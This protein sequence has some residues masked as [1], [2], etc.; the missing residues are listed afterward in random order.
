MTSHVRV[1]ASPNPVW[2]TSHAKLWTRVLASFDEP[3]K[4]ALYVHVP[5]S[6]LSLE[7]LL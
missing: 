5:Q 3:R 7:V 6:R 1:T 2:A 4:A